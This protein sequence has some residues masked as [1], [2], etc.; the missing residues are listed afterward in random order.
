MRKR[1][2]KLYLDS[3]VI[4]FLYADDAPEYKAVTLDFFKNYL[5]SYDVYISEIVLLESERTM[6]LNRRKLLNNA[7]EQYGLE[8]YGDLNNE[9]E[10]IANK[11]VNVPPYFSCKT[12]MRYT[13]SF[14]HITNSTY[15]FHGILDILLIFLNKLVSMRS[16]NRKVIQ[17]VFI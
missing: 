10:E 5:Y 14:A 11:Y 9:I 15:S 6:D 3:S 12:T 7:L 8:V 4:N 2:L 1:K 17:N 16:M 13:W